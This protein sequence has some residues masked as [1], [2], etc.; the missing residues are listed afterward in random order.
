MNPSI[1][2]SYPI[3]HLKINDVNRVSDVSKTAGGKGLNVSRVIKLMGQDVLATGL[4]GGHFGH[5]IEDK[6]DEDEIKHDF[7][8]IHAETRNSIALLHD[9]GKQTEVLEPGPKITQIDSDHFATYF[10]KLIEHVSVVTMSG[11]LPRGLDDSYYS[12]LVKIINSQE[13]K[14]LLDTSGSSFKKCLK[15]DSKPYLI[16][17]NE[18]EIGELIGETLAINDSQKLSYQL[19]NT[20]L[21]SIPWVVVSLG[22]KGA[23]AK[24]NNKIYR[25][26]IPTIKAVNPVGSGDSTLAGLAIAISNNRNDEDI[27]K[28]G[29]TTGI[30]NTLETQTGFIN[31][32]NFNKYFDK[33]QVKEI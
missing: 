15:S 14:A 10:K 5:F 24:H 8:H 33:I 2:M 18:R 6:L 16:K 30:L 27:L 3:S 21:E 4:I 32:D 12:E 9:N 22:S 1:D 29:M 13:K 26:T 31:R 7:V 25:V 20:L 11:S 23:I 19:N 17:P 28:T